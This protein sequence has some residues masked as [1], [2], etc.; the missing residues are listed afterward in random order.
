M[1]K[2]IYLYL[3]TLAIFDINKGKASLTILYPQH[4]PSK[5]PVGLFQK[6]SRQGGLRIWNFQG[7]Q[8][9]SMWNFQGLIKNKVKFPRMTKKK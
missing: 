3:P 5:C 9:K 8:R 6:K 1:H 2:T 4:D 7:Y